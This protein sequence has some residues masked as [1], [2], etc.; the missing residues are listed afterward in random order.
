MECIRCVFS[1]GLVGCCCCFSINPDSRLD[2]SS[3][4]QIHS[5][6]CS[7]VF[8]LA[9]KL[10]LI[11][12]SR[13]IGMRKQFH[14]SSLLSRFLLDVL[15]LDA[16]RRKWRKPVSLSKEYAPY[17]FNP[18]LAFTPAE[19]C[20]SDI[21]IFFCFFV[22]MEYFACCLM[23]V[24][25]KARNILQFS[26]ENT[27]HFLSES[28]NIFIMDGIEKQHRMMRVRFFFETK[29]AMHRT[30]CMVHAKTHAFICPW[31]NLTRIS[32]SK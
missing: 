18:Y 16:K 26:W 3:N 10:S 23:F 22:L 17:G 1:N 32:L 6:F 5:I 2:R 30:I 21:S 14:E 27:S 13:K 19:N 24:L 9:I 15:F 12:N 7:H 4:T 31:N 28:H 8:G 25:Q 11:I 29:G 20:S